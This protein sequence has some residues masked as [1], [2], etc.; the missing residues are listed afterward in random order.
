MTNLHEDHVRSTTTTTTGGVQFVCCKGVD[1]ITSVD[2]IDVHQEATVRLNGGGNNL[3]H[4]QLLVKKGFPK[5]PPVNVQFTDITYTTWQLSMM[6][7]ARGKWSGFMFNQ[8]F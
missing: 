8:L 7:C 2:S 4:Q 3:A 6:D 1:C 5:R